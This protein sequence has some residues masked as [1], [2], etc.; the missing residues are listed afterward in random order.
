MAKKNYIQTKGGKFY[1]NS[2]KPVSWE[3]RKKYT[4]QIL[5]ENKH[6]FD[7]L[8]TIP[9]IKLLGVTGSVAAYNADKRSDID[10]FIIT[11][12]NRLW[13]TRGFTA[14]LLKIVNAYVRVDAEPGKICPN[15]FIDE[16]YLTW[17]PEKRN[18]YT[19]HE[20]CMLQPIFQRDDAYFRFLKANDW[21]KKYFPNFVLDYPEAFKVKS[22]KSIVDEI[23]KYVMGLQI[24]YMRK[25]KTKEITEKHI[26][27]FNKH[28]NGP[29]ILEAFKKY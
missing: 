12:K 1:L 26:I 25:K 20:I 19:A 3:L 29:R 17:P 14:L 6:I 18:V 11:S 28:D 24:S 22:K 13:L 21:V 10:I 4:E 15:L 8:K 7:L 9:W 2:I 27:H 16:S 23:E 5:A